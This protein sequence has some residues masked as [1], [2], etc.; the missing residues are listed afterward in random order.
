MPVHW[1]ESTKRKVT[2]KSRVTVSRVWGNIGTQVVFLGLHWGNPNT[3][4]D[5]YT[6]IGYTDIRFN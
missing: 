5:H 3:A 2:E 6:Q 4:I 1:D